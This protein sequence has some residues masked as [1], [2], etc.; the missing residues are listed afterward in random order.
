[1]K[2]E[3]NKTR[4]TWATKDPLYISYHDKEWGRPVHEDQKLFEFLILEG[5]QAGLSWITILRKRENY[6]K[7]FDNF[8]PKKVANYKEKKI[9][10]LLANE[11]I[12]R[13]QLKI[14][15]A[16]T[17]AQLFL[18]IQKEYGSFDKYIWGF[19]NQKTIYN[20]WKTIRES[21]NETLESKT[22]S[23]DLK[24]RGFKFV[25]STICYAFMQATGM[26]MDHT[27]DCFCFVKKEL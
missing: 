8:D 19:V 5:A 6:R 14:R 18:N 3:S 4:C 7:A 27:T 9:Q 24:K 2:K 23:K 11:G 17:N 21:P 10:S 26:V 16:V 20:S 15:S 13:N 1:M 22:M 25:G 12:I